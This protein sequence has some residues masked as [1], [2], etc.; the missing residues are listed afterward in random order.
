MNFLDAH[1]DTKLPLRLEEASL[2]KY[3][4]QQ[5]LLALWTGKPVRVVAHFKME[6]R[7]FTGLLYRGTD[8]AYWIV[9]TI[10][11][12][13]VLSIQVEDPFALTIHIS[14]FEQ[15]GLSTN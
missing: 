3:F 7:T 14:D 13:G 12:K 2:L 11:F 1:L 9:G 8:G 6:T 10:S 15:I 4:I 5:T